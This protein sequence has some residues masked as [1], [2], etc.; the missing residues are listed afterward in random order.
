[1]DVRVLVTTTGPEA[2]QAGTP[3]VVEIRDT[4]VLDV[5][6]TTVC[7]QATVS[8]PAGEA[9]ATDPDVVPPPGPAVADHPVVAAVDLIVPERVQGLAGLTV[10]ARVAQDD[11]AH[12]AA[13]DW[14]TVQAYPV[15]SETVV[16]EVVQV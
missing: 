15:E 9:P 2:P 5:A 10:W 3:V 13:G 4:S 1:M 12:V 11:H 7:A 8:R 6:S 16:V 14:I